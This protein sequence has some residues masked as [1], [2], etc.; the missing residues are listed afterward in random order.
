MQFWHFCGLGGTLNLSR[1]WLPLFNFLSWHS[2]IH[3]FTAHKLRKPDCW[4]VKDDDFARQVCGKHGQWR[5]L[6]DSK[7][8]WKP[9]QKQSPLTIATTVHLLSA[10]KCCSLSKK[11]GLINP[12]RV[13]SNSLLPAQKTA[14]PLALG[15]VR[16]LNLFARLFWTL[17]ISIM[18]SRTINYKLG[19]TTP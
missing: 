12:Y 3:V 5:G 1:L 9:A 18:T 17:T 6:H 2:T 8:C 19:L 10:K 4:S 16:K 15:K 14:R 13:G 11:L 7:L